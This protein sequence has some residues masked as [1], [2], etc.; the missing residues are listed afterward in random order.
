MRHSPSISILKNVVTARWIPVS[1]KTKMAAQNGG[2]L[3]NCTRWSFIGN[4]D[5]IT[6]VVDRHEEGSVSV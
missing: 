4:Y 6:D 5:K 1:G 2:R 3:E